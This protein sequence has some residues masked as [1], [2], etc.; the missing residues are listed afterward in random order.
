[1][2]VDVEWSPLA[3]PAG[4]GGRPRDDEAAALGAALARALAHGALDTAS[5]CVAPG[6]AVW[7]VYIDALLLA[8]DG[9][10]PAALS[11][12]AA[13]ALA[14]ARVPR[15]TVAAGDPPEVEVDD[16]LSVAVPLDVAGVPVTI[17]V[18]VC[19]ASAVADPDAAEEAAAGALVRVAVDAA[20]RVRGLDLARGGLPA[21]GLAAAVALA[22]GAA[23]GQRASVHAAAAAA[24][25]AAAVP[26]M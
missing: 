14:D 11:L 19:G 16:D 23:P 17:V 6:V 18:A 8:A 2:H 21:G 22:R 24:K 3:G 5:L 1:V 7:H 26:A 10:A 13:A 25:D 12:A 20:G 9:G 15:A 4:G